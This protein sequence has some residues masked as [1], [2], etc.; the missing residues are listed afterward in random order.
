MSQYLYE[1]GP[2]R[3]DVAKRL[4]VHQSWIALLESG[5]RRLD[6]VEF[7]AVAKAIEQG[8]S[9]IPARMPRQRM[10][11]ILGPHY[12]VRLQQGEHRARGLGIRQRPAPGQGWDDVRDAQLDPAATQVRRQQEAVSPPG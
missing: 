3:I 9:S 8:A 10:K 5:Q 4:R 2:F 7:L 12:I 11:E 1:F 6:V